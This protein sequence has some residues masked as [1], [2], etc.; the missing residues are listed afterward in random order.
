MELEVP[1]GLDLIIIL[2]GMD[3]LE[4]AVV[5]MEMEVVME[6]AEVE[7]MVQLEVLVE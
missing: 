5:E 4:V 2:L 3:L 6:T 7:G 1:D